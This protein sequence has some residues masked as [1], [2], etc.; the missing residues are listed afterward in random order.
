[1]TKLNE[2]VDDSNDAI[3]KKEE[4]EEKAETLDG[5]IRKII[6]EK[7]NFIMEKLNVLQSDA[8]DKVKAALDT[9]SQKKLDMLKNTQ[10][11][12]GETEDILANHIR[13]LDAQIGERKDALSRIELLGKDADIDVSSSLAD[14]SD[15]IE[16]MNGHR[17]KIIEK[18][19]VRAKASG[20]VIVI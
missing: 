20:S 18:L 9:Q 6:E 1:M 11:E 19:R 10:T 13:L 2:F 3:K 17:D 14:V 4:L 12:V 5:H 15:E 16:K 8:S 7:D